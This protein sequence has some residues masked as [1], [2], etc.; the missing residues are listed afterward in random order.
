MKSRLLSDRTALA[1]FLA[2]LGARTIMYLLRVAAITFWPSWLPGPAFFGDFNIYSSDVGLILHGYLPYRDIPFNYG[3]LYLYSMV[4]FYVLTQLLSAFPT[5]MADALTALIV[6]RLVRDA[7]GA[8]LALASGLAYA[9]SPFVLVNEGYLWMSSQPMTMFI[10]LSLY[11]MRRGRLT[12]SMLSIALGALFKQEALFILPVILWEYW[13]Q[14]GRQVTRGM[15]YSALTYV[16]GISPFLI[17]APRATLYSLAY[18]VFPNIGPIEKSHLSAG[19]LGLNGS[20]L[21]TTA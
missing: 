3:P 4:P 21:V 11:Q 5:V 16:I 6:Y 1:L 18:G 12:E 14:Q 7:S 13:R 8:R 10:V 17:L 20:S 15:L 2:A 9:L 19:V